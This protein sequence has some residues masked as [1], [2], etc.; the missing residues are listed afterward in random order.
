MLLFNYL[1]QLLSSPHFVHHPPMIPLQMEDISI[2]ADSLR[3]RVQTLTLET[4]E[5]G[6]AV[7]ELRTLVQDQNVKIKDRDDQIDGMKVQWVK[8][9]VKVT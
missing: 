3:Q 9:I 4:R 1:G 5:K 6:A 8:N 2:E 7:D